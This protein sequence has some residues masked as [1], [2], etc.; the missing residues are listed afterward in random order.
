MENLCFVYIIKLENIAIVIK[1]A[2]PRIKKFESMQSVHE[3][4]LCEV[5]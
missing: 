2:C 5:Y 4:G 3:R 1:Q